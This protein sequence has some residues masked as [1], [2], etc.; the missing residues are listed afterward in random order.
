M[1]D[2]IEVDTI[3]VVETVYHSPFQQQPTSIA[4]RFSRDLTTQAQP[5]ERYLTAT[6][7]WD[8]L[9]YGWLEDNIG[10]LIIHNLEGEFTQTIPTPEEKE[11][12][13]KRILEIAFGPHTGQWIIPPRESMR[14]YPTSV[15]DLWIRCSYK[16]AKYRL[17]L[18][19]G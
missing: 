13:E 19:P 9:D 14:G 2:S 1:S 7:K 6:E 17:N 12:A 16:T 18:L 4:T 10:M 8:L 15:S 11:D 5:Y 3:T